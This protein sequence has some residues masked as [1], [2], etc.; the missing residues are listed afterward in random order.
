MRRLGIRI[1]NALLFIVC[2]YAAAGLFNKINSEVLAP[3]EEIPGIAVAAA[4]TQPVRSPSRIRDINRRNLFGSTVRTQIAAKPEPEP[5]RV[6]TV[7]KLPLK[8]L[9]TAAFPRD[10]TA[11]RAGLRQSD[12]HHE[13]S[14]SHPAMRFRGKPAASKTNLAGNIGFIGIR[15]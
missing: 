2:C 7:T 10:E 3:E 9:G 4:P 1:A 13:Y 12:Q 15:H 5:E 8:L 14:Q 6:T 11:S